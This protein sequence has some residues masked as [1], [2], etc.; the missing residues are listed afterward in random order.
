MAIDPNPSHSPNKVRPA[1]DHAPAGAVNTS[2]AASGGQE[3]DPAEVDDTPSMS[4]RPHAPATTGQPRP[5]R[6]PGGA[7]SD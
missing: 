2:Q 5:D 6:A 7:V 1:R 3:Y 4:R